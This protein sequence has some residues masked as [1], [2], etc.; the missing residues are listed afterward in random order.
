MY[1]HLICYGCVKC[2]TIWINHG[3][4][5]FKLNVEE[6][7]DCSHDDIVGFWNDKFRYV[8]QAEGS[9]KGP[10]EDTKKY[11]NLL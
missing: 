9:Y 1:D 11:Y 6:D 7:M 10:N 2:Y 5:D 4:W 8:A 3:E